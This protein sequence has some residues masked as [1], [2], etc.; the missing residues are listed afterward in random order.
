MRYR[1]EQSEELPAVAEHTRSM[2]RSADFLAARGRLN[3]ARKY[4]QQYGRLDKEYPNIRDARAKLV[5]ERGNEAAE[6]LIQYVE[7]LAPYL[8]QRA[9]AAELIEWCNDAIAASETLGMNPAWLYLRRGEAENHLGRW[10]AN[11][12]SL[13]SAIKLSRDEDEE[14]YARS[15]LALGRLQL[16]QGAYETALATLAEVE[17]LLS[18]EHHFEELAIA[19]SEVAAYHLNRGELDEALAMYQQANQLRRKAGASERSDHILMM[20]GVVERKMGHYEKAEEYLRE[21][22]ER[23]ESAESKSTVATASH[24]LAWLYINQGN[25]SQARLYCRKAIVL[26]DKIQDP[27]GASDA[28][29]QLGLIALAEGKKEEAVTHLE[30]SLDTRRTIGNQHGAASSLRHLALAHFKV[31]HPLKAGIELLQ[32]LRLYW[33][34]GVLTRQRI[35]S[36]GRELLE[37]IFG[38]QRWTM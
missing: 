12:A 28:S 9:L 33:T 19:R 24:H 5:N 4:Q 22:L 31:G 36:I 23:G 3:L 15:L 13:L 29:E 8:L 25:L 34:L 11:E 30:R 21:L 16:N 37:W 26:Y 18:A 35:R 27:R 7:L 1:N 20:M 17:D 32:S 6:V 14:T 10:A 38:Q 2:W